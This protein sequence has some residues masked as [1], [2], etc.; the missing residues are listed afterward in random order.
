ML[1]YL[2]KNTFIIDGSGKDGFYG[3]VGIQG[4]KIVSVSK[5]TDPSIQAEHVIDG[6]GLVT[7][8]GFIDIHSHCDLALPDDPRGENYLLQGITTYLGGHCGL[9]KAPSRGS[10]LREFKAGSSGAYYTDKAD[11]SSYDAWLSTCAPEGTGP[12]YASLVGDGPIRGSV[13]GMDYT[14]A[15]TA[16][17]KKQMIAL[18]KEALDAGAFGLS[19]N[20]DV[21]VPGYWAD[22]EEVL[23]LLK[24]VQKR[25]KL[26]SPHTRFHQNSW[27]SDDE[28]ECVYGLIPG[29]PGEVITGR[30]HGLIEAVEY[31][32]RVP[33]TK[34]LI[35][36]VTP[37]Y[38]I[39]QPHPEYVDRAIAQAAMEE[40]VDAP[41]REGVDVSFSVI[42]SDNSVGTSLYVSNLFF[43]KR[44]SSLWP[45][46][47]KDGGKAAFIKG[48][49]DRSFRDSITK[50]CNSGRMKMNMA[51]PAQ[52][53]YWSEC[54]TII[55]CLRP[56]YVGKTVFE[57]ALDRSPLNVS[58]A[59]YKGA[60]EVL[61]DILQEDPDA[62][63]A[64][65]KDKREAGVY[66]E[67]LKHPWSMPM[68]DSQSH[69]Y[70]I[71]SFDPK[72]PGIAPRS[73]SMFP[74]Y[75]LEMVKRTGGLSLQEA[76]RHISSLPAEIA[77]FN[78]R[79]LLKE[80]NFADVVIM[81]W[82]GLKVHHDFLHPN[83]GADGIEYVFVN[84][85]LACK[86]KMII[87][88]QAGKVLR[89]E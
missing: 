56:E 82:D 41:R 21:C 60:F 49:G 29:M 32:K 12:N 71:S 18:L 36:H 81:N 37:T 72:C 88:A 44:Q 6:T 25:G 10:F 48:L 34:L 65:T 55:S 30:M 38:N 61:Y 75:L 39:P 2:I 19:V 69:P 59:V 3:S 52:D 80:D 76:I 53:P 89:A 77:G 85:R 8:P 45:Q 67:F 35:S 5:E 13:L 43:H 27:Y 50:Y 68:T 62:V 14:R 86:G 64:F 47:Y 7:C 73:Y 31:A 15:S 63:C 28:K 83:L 20:H 70:D 51:C 4:E 16:D 23:M 9:G 40:L 84:G 79:G 33:G 87:N 22:E 57:L 46:F 17:E 66:T 24:A 78:G 54:F 58:K 1:D 74:H 42:P 26:F 11:T